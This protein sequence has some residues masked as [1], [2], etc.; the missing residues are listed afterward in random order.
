MGRSRFNS[1]LYYCDKSVYPIPNNHI[2][3]ERLYN[4]NKTNYPT[5]IKSEMR[6]I[7]FSQ[8]FLQIVTF[9]LSESYKILGLT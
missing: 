4:S 2:R 7:Y 3:H 1:I 9:H 6:V 8:A 5:K